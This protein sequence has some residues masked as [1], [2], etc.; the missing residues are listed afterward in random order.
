MVKLMNLWYLMKFKEGKEGLNTR[1]N[2][3]A[4][5]ANVYVTTLTLNAVRTINM[6]GM[7]SECA[8]PL[9]GRCI[10]TVLIHHWPMSSHKK[11]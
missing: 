3:N 6:D 5:L 11:T 2:S 8:M 1:T 4:F 10:Q 7:K 9:D